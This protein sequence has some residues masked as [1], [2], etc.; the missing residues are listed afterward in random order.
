MR[1]GAADAGRPGRGGGAARDRAPVPNPQTVAT[2]IR[3]GNPARLGQALAARRRSRTAASGRSTTPASWP[4]TGCWPRTRACSASRPRRPRWRPC[5]RRAPTAWSS[6]GSTVVC[7]LTG[8][9][10]KDPDTAGPRAPRSSAARRDVERLEELALAPEPVRCL[11]GSRS[12]APASS[13]NLGPGFDCL[14]V[15]LE[16]RNEVV[17]SAPRRRPASRVTVEGEGAD[18]PPGRRATCSC[19]RSRPPAPTRQGCVH[20]AKRGAVRPRAGIERRDH[21]RRGCSP[22]PAWCG[23]D[24]R[25][26][27]AGGRARGPPRQR[28]RGAHRRADAG[29]ERPATGRGRCGFEPRRSSFVVRDRRGRALDGRARGRRCPRRCRTPTRCTR[30]PRAALLVAALEAGDADL[31][32]PM[33]STTVCTSRTGRRSCR[34]SATVAGARSST[35]RS[36]ARR[37]RAR[38][39]R[40][41]SGASREAA[42]MVAARLDG[43][44]ARALPLAVADHGVTVS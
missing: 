40:C 19:G 8:H 29:L 17:V 21:R 36:L 32:S 38:G 4:P 13:A 9:G 7:V 41:S 14:A 31:P 25:P 16:L 1:R 30:R 11:T 15:A 43:V 28:R 20:D 12:T 42:S 5:S 34:C 3:I 39:R 37:S 23:D 6:P 2:A 35:S 18:E 22:A 26:A 44:G 24:G 27:P 10:L 33:R